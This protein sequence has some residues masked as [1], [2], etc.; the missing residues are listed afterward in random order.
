MREF[1]QDEKD[2]FTFLWSAYRDWSLVHECMA[3]V[4]P[5]LRDDIH[6]TKVEVEQR[7][8]DKGT[9]L[10]KYKWDPKPRLREGVIVNCKLSDG[11]VISV[12]LEKAYFVKSVVA[13]AGWEQTKPKEN[14]PKWHVYVVRCADDSLYCGTTTDVV[15]RVAEHNTS[16]RGA[17]YTRSRRPV[18][19]VQSWPMRNR[20]E[21]VK[22][23]IRF[24]SL[25]KTE[26]EQAVRPNGSKS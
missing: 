25:S 17:K 3:H 4:K 10:K 19:L 2:L 16:P 9:N 21:A 15:R 13:L 23:E 8:P 14:E 20:S 5:H 12:V 22:A 11:A 26:K 24:K 18:S 7:R 1:T 6:V